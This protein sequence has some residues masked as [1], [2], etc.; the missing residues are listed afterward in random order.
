MWIIR[1]QIYYIVKVET[2]ENAPWV[3]GAIPTMLYTKLTF[4]SSKAVRTRK[5]T[6]EFLQEIENKDYI[7]IDILLLICCWEIK[8]LYRGGSGI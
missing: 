4:S 7:T 5:C 8:L 6:L 1:G 2:E 3:E